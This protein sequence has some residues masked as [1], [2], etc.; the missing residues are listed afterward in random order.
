MLY[1]RLKVGGDYVTNIRIGLASP[2]DREMCL[3]E[4]LEDFVD[5]LLVEPGN[6]RIMKMGTDEAMWVLEDPEAEISNNDLTLN[7]GHRFR[8]NPDPGWKRNT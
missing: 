3:F 2:W 6:K 1:F 8:K 5:G 4:A 7:I